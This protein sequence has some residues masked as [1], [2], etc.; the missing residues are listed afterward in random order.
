MYLLK[1]AIRVS[2]D[3]QS[4]TGF[5]RLEICSGQPTSLQALQV[6]G[7]NISYTR[8][9]VLS[10]TQPPTHPPTYTPTYLH[11]AGQ[12]T[13]VV[14]SVRVRQGRAYYE[15]TISSASS[16]S[17]TKPKGVRIGWAA[18]GSMLSGMYLCRYVLVHSIPSIIYV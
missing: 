10:A 6:A 4:Y 11:T 2:N 9:F 14:R 8:H 3:D 12:V 7:M 13:A 5:P 18:A 1:Y 15:A 16:S 17:S